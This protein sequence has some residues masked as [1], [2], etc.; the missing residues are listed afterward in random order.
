MTGTVKTV[1][2][3]KTPDKLSGVSYMILSVV[4]LLIVAGLSWCFYRAITAATKEVPVEPQKP[5]DVDE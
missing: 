4:F 1:E 5:E 3:V 2:T